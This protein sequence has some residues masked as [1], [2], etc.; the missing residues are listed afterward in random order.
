MP[1]LVAVRV[2]LAKDAAHEHI[3][4][5][6]YQ[7][8]HLKAEPVMVPQERILQKEA[9]GEK[10][11]VTVDGE[12]TDLVGG[13]CPACGIEPYLRTAKDEG[14]KERLRDLPPG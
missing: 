14:D 7:S 2:G 10:F 11:W 4:L 6:G 8:D 12:R 13:K 1:E 9:L 5:V 3:E